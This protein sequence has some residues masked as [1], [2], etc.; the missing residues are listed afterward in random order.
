MALDV[1]HEQVRKTED[2]S[3]TFAL[4]DE[5]RSASTPEAERGEA[6]RTLGSLEDYRSIGPL[7][8]LVEDNSLPEPVRE[9][10]SVML[11]GFDDSTTG[12]R[13]RGWWKS[14]DPVK[15]AHALRLMEPSEADIVDSVA[16][17]DGHPLQRLALAAMAFGFDQP[18]FQPVKI[19]ALDHPDADVR[20]EAADVLLWDEPV[21]AERPLLSAASDPNNDVAAAAVNTL[22]YYPSRCVL[23]ALAE[24]AA[25]EDDQVR[26]KATESLDYN[27]GRFEYLATFGGRDE[28]ALLREWMALVA[29]LV[30]WS[31]EVQDREASS[32]PAGRSRVAMSEGELLAALD[33]RRGGHR[34]ARADSMAR[35]TPRARVSGAGAG[36]SRGCA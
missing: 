5:V 36:G 9:A 31:D 19:R 27:C 23:R 26:A 11:A 16:G 14:G 35:D 29:D 17:D 21:A 8:A 7:T 25:A 15:M 6:F 3:W 4:L 34:H 32:P 12:E 22:Q 28:V 33:D 2:R 10:A 18:E 1:Q 13:R 30:R 20:K 24:F